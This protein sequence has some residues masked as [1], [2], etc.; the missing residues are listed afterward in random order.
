M[1]ESAGNELI[2]RDAARV[3]ILACGLAY[4]QTGEE[5]GGL[6]IMSVAAAAVG[7]VQSAQDQHVVTDRLKRSQAE[8]EFEIG[9]RLARH[10]GVHVRAVGEVE[11]RH[12]H[13]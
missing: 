3:N 2:D 10:P 12:P 13:R 1:A 8:G 9:P 4:V 5:I 11:K 6:R 7:L